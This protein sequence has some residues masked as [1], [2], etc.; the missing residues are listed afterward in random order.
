MKHG[1]WESFK[2]EYRKEGKLCE[3]TFERIREASE[4]VTMDDV[5]RLGHC[6]GYPEKKH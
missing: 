6:T 4:K 2:E 3:R 5:G 1:N